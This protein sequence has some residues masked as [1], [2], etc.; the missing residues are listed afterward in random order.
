MAFEELDLRNPS[1]LKC[2]GYRPKYKRDPNTGKK[3]YLKSWVTIARQSLTDG[4]N[5]VDVKSLEDDLTQNI[6]ECYFEIVDAVIEDFE[7]GMRWRVAFDIDM[8]LWKFSID[9]SP[10]AEVTPEQCKALSE[11]EYFKKFA[12]KCGQII[13]EADQVFNKIVNYHLENGDLLKVPEVKLGRIL[14]SIELKWWM[15]NLRQC[16]Y[17]IK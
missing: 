3:I 8:G 7:S 14:Y 16:K 4:W 2:F 10:D 15:D 6:N 13:D 11:S 5:N 1:D 9:K 17:A 12:R